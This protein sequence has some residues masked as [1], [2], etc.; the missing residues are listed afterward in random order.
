MADRVAVF[1]DGE[2]IPADHAARIVVEAAR[3]GR[4]D[5]LRVYGNTCILPRWQ[6]TPGY[7]LV[8]AGTGKNAADLLLAIEVMEHVLSAACD[9][10]LIASSDADFTHL[11]IRLRERGLKV[12]GLG[13]AK[14]SPRFR[15]AC[16]DSVE[17]GPIAAKPLAKA[18]AAPVSGVSDL[19]RKIRSVIAT[20]ST[21]GQGMQIV[22]LSGAMYARHGIRI[23]TFPERT[24]RSYLA[25]RET[26]YDLD[27]RG[28]QARVRFRPGGFTNSA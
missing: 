11:A 3:H 8:H 7:R 20:N 10:V 18:D 23:S 6:E 4:T 25:A 16:T 28:Q 24:W 19:D 27:P 14:T 22:Q 26:L 2:N 5:V 9:C 13:E 15:A 21:N 12:V 17:L 1:V